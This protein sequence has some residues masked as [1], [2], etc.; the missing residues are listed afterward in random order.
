MIQKYIASGFP[1]ASLVES[2]ERVRVSLVS[3]TDKAEGEAY[4]S[5]LRQRTEYKNVWLLSVRNR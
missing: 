3:F 1:Q 4:V 2:D 5:E